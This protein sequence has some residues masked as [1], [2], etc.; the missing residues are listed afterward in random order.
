MCLLCLVNIDMY[1]TFRLFLLCFRG[2]TRNG[3]FFCGNGEKS[4]CSRLFLFF[5]VLRFGGVT[6]LYP[7][8]L[9][10][11]P[12]LS[13]LLESYIFLLSSLVSV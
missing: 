8:Y 11:I 13:G 1:S 5:F 12:V 10:L 6:V 9:P 2:G 3:I 4:V 7:L